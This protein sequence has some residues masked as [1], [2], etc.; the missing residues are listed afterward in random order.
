MALARRQE[1]PEPE[2]IEMLAGAVIHDP[3]STPSEQLSG[4]RFWVPDFLR[5]DPAVYR[6]AVQAMPE[7]QVIQAQTAGVDVLLQ[8]VPDGVELCDARG[9]H[10]SSTAEWAL[11]ALLSLLREFPRFERARQQRR[12]DYSMTDELAGKRV[13]I[14]GAGDVGQQL[15]RR[16]TACDASP[17][18]VAR[19]AR[20]GV[21][22]VAELP[23]LLP[24]ADAVVLIVPKTTE[25]VGMVDAEFLAAMPDGA[26]L[27]N[28]ARGPVVDTAALLAELTSGRLRAAI[29]VVDPEPLPSD[30]PLWTAPNLLLT[31][32]VA[33]SVLGFGDRFAGLLV[34][35]LHRYLRQEP[36]QNTVSGQY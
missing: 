26:I 11:T 27:V 34:R 6:T 19:T 8:V 30:H 23:D 12:W 31:P 5:G 3:A 4:V 18:F 7:L 15:A 21:H 10:G 16:I 28:A 1:E 14:I 9:V 32:H 20:E 13:L 33:G 17:V 24:E 35:Q 2:L 22:S 29:D 25:T 36:L